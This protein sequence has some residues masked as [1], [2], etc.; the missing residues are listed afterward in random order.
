MRTHIHTH[1]HTGA[2]AG[3]ED[4]A[5]G[6]S[7]WGQALEASAGNFDLPATVFEE[8]RAMGHQFDDSRAYDDRV[9]GSSLLPRR[10]APP[11]PSL[12]RRAADMDLRAGMY[13]AVSSADVDVH[14]PS[15]GLHG[16]KLVGSACNLDRVGVV[17]SVER[18][19]ES[20]K[21]VLYDACQGLLHVVQQ[22]IA[23]MDRLTRFTGGIHSIDCSNH[24]A[25][26][27]MSC[28]LDSKLACAYARACVVA[29]I[30]SYNGGCSLGSAGGLSPAFGTNAAAV[31]PQGATTGSGP[32]N[33]S[34]G[35]ECGSVD[36]KVSGASL[37]GGNSAGQEG[38]VVLHEA[39]GGRP[40][41]M[42]LILAA[43]I[44]QASSHAVMYSTCSNNT[45]AYARPEGASGLSHAVTSYV[46][47]LLDAELSNASACMPAEEGTKV[48]STE[49]S[50]KFKVKESPKRKIEEGISA[51]S[52][53]AV[54]S[55]DNGPKSDAAA[56]DKRR[57]CGSDAEAVG[58]GV[59]S[60]QTG[61]AVSKAPAHSDSAQHSKAQVH[62][63]MHG[64]SDKQ[65]AASGIPL[66]SALHDECVQ[67]LRNASSGASI[68]EESSEHPLIRGASNSIGS[69]VRRC[70]QAEGVS[71]LFVAFDT[72]CAL[73]AGESI[74][75]YGDAACTDLIATA[76]M[77]ER[78]KAYQ[79]LILPSPV[80]MQVGSGNGSEDGEST[81]GYRV[82]G[83]PLAEKN[84]ATGTWLAA[85]FVGRLSAH[86]PASNGNVHRASTLMECLLDLL[87]RA[88]SIAPPHCM[89]LHS[90]SAC[91]VPEIVRSTKGHALLATH[92]TFAKLTAEVQLRHTWE[93]K[94]S[95]SDGGSDGSQGP[96]STYLG[97]LCELLA[98]RSAALQVQQFEGDGAEFAAQVFV[99]GDA[100]G[101]DDR[102][103]LD[104]LEADRCVGLLW[105]SCLTSIACVVCV[106]MQ[107]QSALHGWIHVL[108]ASNRSGNNCE[109]QR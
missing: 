57:R 87:D 74:K 39:M 52:S 91:L 78:R 14:W 26:A 28:D 75:F 62:V 105:L 95:G 92:C 41:L 77:D 53:Y 7:A 40:R 85:L 71:K 16:L 81:W 90:L 29:V 69:S 1:I 103:D 84:L 56:R 44:E 42:K 83:F 61:A 4:S 58:S 66:S 59:D 30:A 6:A 108:I 46:H 47:A 80:W 17:E 88:K 94:A 49:E 33:C 25:L 38:V 107:S 11:I 27:R 109:A 22:P 15:E 3:A 34:E 89:Q 12:H 8:L 99:E 43:A 18:G 68:V 54:G 67:A 86:T 70:L 82:V 45:G 93:T 9:F 96:V 51:N 72:R 76:T 79:P 20:A 104:R 35:S 55:G 23:S 5:G 2:S 32:W 10:G 48:Y 37:R 64:L 19:S 31:P 73:L 98:C 106:R 65:D 97:S 60:L 101:C 36:S 21:V 102:M 50:D 100:A 24:E 63:H 13:I